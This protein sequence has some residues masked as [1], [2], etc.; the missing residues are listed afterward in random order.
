MGPRLGGERGHLWGRLVSLPAHGDQQRDA[1]RLLRRL[2]AAVRGERVRHNDAGKLERL[3][4]VRWRE[5]QRLHSI[6]ATEAGEASD[7]R[8]VQ[9]DCRKRVLPRPDGELPA[10]G[11]VELTAGGGGRTAVARCEC[12]SG[13][14]R[15]RFSALAETQVFQIPNALCLQGIFN[16]AF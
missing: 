16:R 13:G 8:A 7:V 2:V 6:I 9:I 4:A 15:F 10:V 3:R 11:R 12:V 14:C 1:R 5:Q